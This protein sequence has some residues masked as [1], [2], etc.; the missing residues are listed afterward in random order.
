MWT[1]FIVYAIATFTQITALFSFLVVPNYVSWLWLVRLGVGLAGYLSYV[2]KFFGYEQA[3]DNKK[4]GTMAL[5]KA[6][7]IEDSAMDTF[8][9]ILKYAQDENWE[10][11]TWD[12][13][14][15]ERAAEKIAELEVDVAE[16]D[17]EQLAKIQ[18]ER[19]ETKS[20]DADAE[21]DAEA[22]ADV[23]AEAGVEA[24]AEDDDEDEEL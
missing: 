9:G 21:A 1:Y 3:H 19:G 23:D 17:A 2:F 22:D 24:D 14:T 20:E 11:A 6:S 13:I 4:T 8:A 12:K 7:M 5:I 16:W 15:W 10:W 18:E